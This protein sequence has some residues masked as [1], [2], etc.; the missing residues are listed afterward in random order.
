[1]SEPLKT[2]NFV[3]YAW[4]AYDSEESCRKAKDALDSITIQDF[5][6]NPVKSMTQRKPI[7]VTP[8]LADDCVER[9][10]E[11]CKRLIS[12]V[13]DPE[14]KIDFAYSKINEQQSKLS[15]N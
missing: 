9:D 3:R 12:E 7:R 13:F 4:V 1:M 5:N 15:N 2:Q 14:K 10:L 8:P 6:L 11:L